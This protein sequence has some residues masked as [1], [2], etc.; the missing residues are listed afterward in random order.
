MVS[1]ALLQS[2]QI[3]SSTTCLLLS[4]VLMASHPWETRHKKCFSLGGTSRPHKRFHHLLSCIVRAFNF[5]STT[6]NLP[7]QY[8]NFTEKSP[9]FSGHQKRES[10]IARMLKGILRVPWAAWFENNL[11]ITSGFHSM[12]ETSISSCTCWSGSNSISVA[13]RAIKPS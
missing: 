11:W 9:R 8:A 1:S 5:V 7:N 3:S 12:E 4:F 13:G 6:L 2:W 10:S